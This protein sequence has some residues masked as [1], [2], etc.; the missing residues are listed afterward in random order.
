MGTSTL[1]DP[2]TEELAT[3]YTSVKEKEI[4]EM[5]GNGL[6]RKQTRRDRVRSLQTE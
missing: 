5:I 6:T 3:G 1:V 4:K 2:Q